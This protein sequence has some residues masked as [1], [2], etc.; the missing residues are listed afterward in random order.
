MHDPPDGE[1]VARD[2]NLEFESGMTLAISGCIRHLDYSIRFEDDIIVR[3]EGIELVN[4][5]I[6]W[7]L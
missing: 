6:P 4:T 3:P 7:A 5:R 2:E 1:W